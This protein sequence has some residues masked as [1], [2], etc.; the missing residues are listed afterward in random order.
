MRGF[1]IQIWER[2]KKEIYKYV[3]V[4]IY[5]YIN[6]V[7]L[8]IIIRFSQNVYRDGQEELSSFNFK[9]GSQTHWVGLEV[10]CGI[11]AYIFH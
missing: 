6:K 4:C 3:Y 10:I 8:N 9:W 11:C 2:K 5:I 1:L 7:F